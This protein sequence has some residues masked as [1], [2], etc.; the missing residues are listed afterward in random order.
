M[1]RSSVGLNDWSG[2][3]RLKLG[4]RVHG[5]LSL[6]SGYEQVVVVKAG[7]HV[8]TDACLGKS[9]GESRRQANRSKVR[10]DR[11]CDPGSG[12]GDRQAERPGECL[13]DD[14]RETFRLA[15]GGDHLVCANLKV[16]RGDNKGICAW[17]ERRLHCGEQNLEVANHCSPLPVA[18][19]ERRAD[20]RASA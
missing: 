4:E 6:I 7:D 8:A 20:F 13:G 5:L 9:V 10:L 16:G 14:E 17:V 19:V 12:V 2:S 11:Q 15:N 3:G 18:G 1:P